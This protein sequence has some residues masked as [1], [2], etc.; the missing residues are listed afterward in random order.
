MLSTCTYK[1]THTNTHTV[2]L[3]LS[4]SLSITQTTIS[5]VKLLCKNTKQGWMLSARTHRHKHVH[6]HSLSHCAGQITSREYK[7][8]VDPQHSLDWQQ[9]SEMFNPEVSATYLCIYSQIFVY[10]CLYIYI[11]HIDPMH[12]LDWLPFFE[13]FNPEANAIYLY[14]FAHMCIHMYIYIYIYHMCVYLSRP[15][16]CWTKYPTLK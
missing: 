9:F 1:H 14:I 4:P 8:G 15:T 7:V 2:S 5:R 3:S 16:L 11:H 13:M 10:I 12:S 6:T